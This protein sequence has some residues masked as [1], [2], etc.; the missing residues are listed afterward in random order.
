MEFMRVSASIVAGMKRLSS[1]AGLVLVTA[2]ALGAVSYEREV[3]PILRTYC[4][5]CHNDVDREGEFSVETFAA[6]AQGG[7]KGRTLVPGQSTDSLLIKLIEGRA[8]PVMPPKDEPR[9]PEAELAVLRRW[10]DEGAGWGKHWAYE[11]PVRPAISE[12]RS[13][14]FGVRNSIDAFVQARLAKEG[15]TPSPAAS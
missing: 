8:K 10:I 4:A 15:I 1:L 9:V 14:E 12:V 3:A 2:S 13:S 7:D 5:G 11:P 6:L